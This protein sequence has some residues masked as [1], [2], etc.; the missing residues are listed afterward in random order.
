MICYASDVNR[1]IPLHDPPQLSV[2]RAC[3]IVI[4]DDGNT[5]RSSLSVHHF[6]R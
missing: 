1:V 3:S 5:F 2:L 4:S 6:T